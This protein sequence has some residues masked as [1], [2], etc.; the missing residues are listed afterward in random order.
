MLSVPKDAARL[1]LT[2]RIDNHHY[3]GTPCS[4]GWTRNDRLLNARGGIYDPALLAFGTTSPQHISWAVE[5]ERFIGGQGW[6][7]GT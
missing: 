4:L 5:L 7:W 6:Q 3:H 2:N 1:P